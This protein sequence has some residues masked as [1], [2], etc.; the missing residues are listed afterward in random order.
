M[1]R[2]RG[3]GHL[4]A[5]EAPE[6]SE[7]AMSISEILPILTGERTMMKDTGGRDRPSREEVG[8]L[9]YHFYENRGRGNGQDV[10]DWLAAERELTNHYR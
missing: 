2:G 6:E 5:G 10:Y 8:R 1:N 3:A 7:A 9:A 4:K